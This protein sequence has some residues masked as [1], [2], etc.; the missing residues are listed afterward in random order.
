MSDIK[1]NKGITPSEKNI[2]RGAVFFR[3]SKV[4]VKVL[5]ATIIIGILIL[6]I[7]TIYLATKSSFTVT[8]Y[9][10]GGTEIASVKAKYGSLIAQ[11]TDPTK[12][13]YVFDGWY[14]DR[15]ATFSWDFSS[16]TV[17][18]SMTLFAKWT[19]K[20]TASISD[21]NGEKEIVANS[22]FVLKNYEIV[23]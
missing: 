9:T 21:S 23:T 12:E 18:D 1:E 8:W 6:F 4:P 7:I 22:V 20:Q 17:Q 19:V 11:P 3:N 10:N 15:D 16:D 2:N 5:S 13:G 14:L